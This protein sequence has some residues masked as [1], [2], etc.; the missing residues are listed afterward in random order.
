MTS[1]RA[2]DASPR[3]G[4]WIPVVAVHRFVIRGGPPSGVGW[5]ADPAGAGRLPPPGARR[6]RSASR[7]ARNDHGVQPD[8]GLGDSGHPRFRED[9]LRP[10]PRTGHTL[11]DRDVGAVL[12]LRHEGPP[13]AVPGG[14]G[15][16]A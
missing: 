3:R 2:P 15:R 8:E 5:T 1:G 11:H 13:P 16:P 9:L 14:T 4:A 10:P 7:P 12:L 6:S